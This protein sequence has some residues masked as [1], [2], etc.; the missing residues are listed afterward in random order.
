[1][2]RVAIN[3]EQE[4][5][6]IYKKA[7]SLFCKGACPHFVNDIFN[8]SQLTSHERK[9]LEDW[10]DNHDRTGF[11]DGK[12]IL[13]LCDMVCGLALSV[14]YLKVFEDNSKQK[15]NP[16]SRPFIN[17]LPSGSPFRDETREAYSIFGA[18]FE[19]DKSNE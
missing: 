5:V 13:A 16:N 7:L 9:E 3:E 1:M 18:K 2:K 17:P 12:S 6:L 14:G 11:L 8:S 15:R 10:V 19:K 4:I